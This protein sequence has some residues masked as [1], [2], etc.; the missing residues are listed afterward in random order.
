MN[1]MHLNE[2]MTSD[3]FS[4]HHYNIICFGYSKSHYCWLLDVYMS[5]K[6]SN[7]FKAQLEQIQQ[8]GFENTMQ[9]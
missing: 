8:E 6:T 9:F 1:N 7:A 3:D 5:K 4:V 2:I